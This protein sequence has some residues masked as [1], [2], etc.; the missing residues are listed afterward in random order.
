MRALRLPDTRMNVER[1]IAS[2]ETIECQERKM[3]MDRSVVRVPSVFQQIQPP[4]QNAWTT[5]KLTL[6]QKRSDE[7]CSSVRLARP[8]RE[9]CP[10]EFEDGGDVLFVSCSTLRERVTG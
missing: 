1:K 9:R 2:S 3:E 8:L 7:V 10:L 6:P 5:I 4:Y